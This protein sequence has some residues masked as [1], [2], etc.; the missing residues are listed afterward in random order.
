M[1]AEQA[2]GE[3]F[4]VLQKRRQQVARL[5]SVRLRAFGLLLRPIENAAQREADPKTNAALRAVR[6]AEPHATMIQID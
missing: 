5:Q 4:L 3:G 2:G 1:T 6:K